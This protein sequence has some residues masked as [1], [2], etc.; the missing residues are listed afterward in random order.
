MVRPVTVQVVF[1]A[2]DGL[3]VLEPGEEVTVWEVMADPLL[4]ATVQL[5]VDWAFCA[6]VATTLV[7]C[8]GA[9]TVMLDDA[10]DAGPVP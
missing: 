7:G 10:E 8:V 2:G 6:P 5:T 3:Q 1:V 9:P 4:D